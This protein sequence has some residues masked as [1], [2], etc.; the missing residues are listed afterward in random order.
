MKKK[1]MPPKSNE[2]L[3]SVPVAI[4][5]AE[6]MEEIFREEC[7]RKVAERET[8]FDFAGAAQYL[9]LSLRTFQ[10]RKKAW[11]LPVAELSPG[12]KIVYRADLDALA[13]SKLV[14]GRSHNVIEFPSLTANAG[15]QKG[16]A[17]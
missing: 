5:S 3:I 17:A 15:L 6:R 16:A 4:P 1:N 10:R 12:L 8:W 9:K 13:M 2:I 11:G 14:K 7:A